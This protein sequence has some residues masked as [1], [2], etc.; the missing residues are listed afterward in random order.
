MKILLDENLSDRLI[1]RLSDLLPEIRHVKQL[2]LQQAEDGAIWDHA[3]QNGFTLVTKDR[4]FSQLC[5]LHGAPPKVVWLRVGNRAT[6]RIAEILRRHHE[7]MCRFV[8]DPQA[9]L[10]ILIE[11]DA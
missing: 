2:G 5:A 6:G 7:A 1:D 9:S 10:L 3:R 11:R 8:A 4:D